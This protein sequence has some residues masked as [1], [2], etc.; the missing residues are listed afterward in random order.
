MGTK[1]LYVTDKIWLKH[2][3]V[4]HVLTV[5]DPA[6][7]QPR[8]EISHSKHSSPRKQTAPSDECVQDPLW[9]ITSSGTPKASLSISVYLSKTP[10]VF[11]CVLVLTTWYDS[12]HIPDPE[13]F[14]L[15]SLFYFPHGCLFLI[16]EPVIMERIGLRFFFPLLWDKV[17][18]W[19][20][21][22]I[23]LTCT[24]APAQTHHEYSAIRVQNG[25]WP[26]HFWY[27]RDQAD[28][29]VS[30]LLILKHFRLSVWQWGGFRGRQIKYVDFA[31]LK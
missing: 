16:C 26:K 23:G 4:H 22:S 2:L 21:K 7:N 12:Q 5:I 24:H 10:Q 28:G 18:G 17:L 6:G 25:T 14:R 1:G 8:S 3:N 27:R 13:T 29:S 15:I 31:L 20:T 30:H 9:F 11:C 19:W